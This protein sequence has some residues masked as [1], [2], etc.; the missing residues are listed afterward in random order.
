[1]YLNWKTTDVN[2]LEIIKLPYLELN[3]A[4][5]LFHGINTFHCN[6]EVVSKEQQAYIQREKIYY[7]LSDELDI[8]SELAKVIEKKKQEPREYINLIFQLPYIQRYLIKAIRPPFP[9]I[10]P[11]PLEKQIFYFCPTEFLV[12]WALSNGILLP[13][14]LQTV[15]RISQHSLSY[16]RCRK[17]EV[18]KICLQAL[19][20]LLWSIEANHALSQGKIIEI[21]KEVIFCSSYQ[22][23]QLAPGFTILTTP[24]FIQKTGKYFK[25]E[26]QNVLR[27]I[28]KV[29]DPRPEITKVGRPKTTDHSSKHVPK[30]IPGIF[31]E[32]SFS[33]PSIHY[34]KLNIVI[35]T[36]GHYLGA[37][38]LVENRE[39]TL[40][41][42]LMSHY[43]SKISSLVNYPN[44]CLESINPKDINTILPIFR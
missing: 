4:I 27:S 14:P 18:G 23:K 7:N 6:F 19:A 9:I 29:I 17:T 24:Y 28:L 13:S 44:F 1:M 41:C 22:G 34:E 2:P 40:N 42:P 43:T 32:T 37:L 20:Q 11:P 5:E 25:E 30:T 16:G 3:E 31:E 26:K 10:S 12:H 33:F 39:Q 21:M 38:Q 35:K 8:P 15:L 36:I